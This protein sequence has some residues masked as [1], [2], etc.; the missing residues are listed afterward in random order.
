M[1]QSYSE[2]S[3][4][5]DGL[6]PENDIPLSLTLESIS[7][8]EIKRPMTL[9]YDRTNIASAKPLIPLNLEG[10]VHVEGNMTHFVTEDLEHKIRLSSPV[11]KKGKEHFVMNRLKQLKNFR[12]A[13][14]AK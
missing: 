2:I 13:V 6:S 4:K 8:E 11:T 9:S 5:S 12:L 7:M 10:S 1:T 3:F 14:S